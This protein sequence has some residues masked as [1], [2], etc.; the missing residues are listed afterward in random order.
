MTLIALCM[1]MTAHATPPDTTINLRT[2]DYYDATPYRFKQPMIDVH[3]ET[4]NSGVTSIVAGLLIT[5]I[6]VVREVTRGPEPIHPNSIHAN[7]NAPAIL[8]YMLVGAGL[9]FTGFGVKLVFNL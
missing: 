7:P 4:F 2:Y 9:G 6:G 1:Y 8:N 3:T 5:S